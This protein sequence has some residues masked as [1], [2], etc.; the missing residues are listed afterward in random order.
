[1]EG[2]EKKGGKEAGIGRGGKSN[3]GDGKENKEEEVRDGVGEVEGE[4]R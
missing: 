1:M 4:E 2:R 3:K